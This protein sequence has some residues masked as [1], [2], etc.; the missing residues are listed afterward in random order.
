MTTS[1]L[2][3][4]SVIGEGQLQKG[5]VRKA[6]TAFEYAYKKAK[7]CGSIEFQESNLVNLA[8]SYL[9][10][11]KPEAAI[12]CLRVAL[13]LESQ[14]P[15]VKVANIYHK[16]ADAY[17][18]LSNYSAACEQYS[19]AHS[20]YNKLSAAD[21]GE[22][23]ANIGIKSGMLHMKIG[24]YKKAIECLNIS[25]PILSEKELVT[26]LAVVLCMK[27]QCLVKSDKTVEEASS[28]CDESF[29]LCKSFAQDIFV[30][31]YNGSRE[32]FN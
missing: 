20:F 5:N 11:E 23:I 2:Q 1:L 24:S 22:V 16:L 25:T 28:T 30:G 27:A 32:A 6:K 9:A 17:E 7:L 29:K 18:Q 14:L 3:K 13:K 21:Q 26:Q 12:T 4:L 31:E 10:A 8:E 19:L 15:D